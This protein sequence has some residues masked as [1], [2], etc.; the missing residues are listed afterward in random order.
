MTAAPPPWQLSVPHCGAMVPSGAGGAPQTCQG[1]VEWAGLILRHG[2]AG[3][4][5]PAGHHNQGQ[6]PD[7]DDD[8]ADQAQQEGPAARAPR[9]QSAHGV[10]T[11]R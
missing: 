11:A 5:D 9:V 1:R 4:V 10:N 8:E 7:A 3:V 2:A 6:G